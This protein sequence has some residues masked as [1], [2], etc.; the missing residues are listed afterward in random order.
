MATGYENHNTEDVPAPQDSIPWT[1]DHKPHYAQTR[2]QE[3]ESS[4]KQ[5]DEPDTHHHL[6]ELQEQFQ[7]LTGPVHPLGT[8][9]HLTMH[10]A[11][12]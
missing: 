4:D 10:T 7:Q 5:S 9:P 11:Y 8:V 3:N 12:S 1:L 6:A 2:K